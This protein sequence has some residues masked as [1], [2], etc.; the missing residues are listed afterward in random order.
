MCDKIQLQQLDTLQQIER[1][2]LAQT[3]HPSEEDQ[4]VL[5][6]SVNPYRLDYKGHNYV[7]ITSQITANLSVEDL[8]TVTALANTWTDISFQEGS[9]LKYADN[10]I[11]GAT[12]TVRA[13]DT[14]LPTDQR[15]GPMVGIAAGAY[16]NNPTQTAAAGADTLYNW[17]TNGTRQVQHTVIQNNTGSNI[18]YAF[19]QSTATGTNQIYVLATG[20]T[21]FWDRAVT[22]LHFASAA[23]QSFGSSS[24]ITV[25]GFL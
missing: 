15:S 18:S 6:T 12:F 9:Q 7:Y 3:T 17:G 20:S 8:A 22:T 14:R 2:L 1:L 21:I 25:E 16:P 4:S 11:T 5:I 19:D 13:T 23:Q 10:G 24:G